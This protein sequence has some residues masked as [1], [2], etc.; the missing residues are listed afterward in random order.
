[1]K[2]R[3]NHVLMGWG[4]ALL[5]AS[6]LFSCSARPPG[7]A[8]TR[9]EGGDAGREAQAE[10][11]V[12]TVAATVNVEA[13]VQ[14]AF[15]NAACSCEAYLVA[16]TPSGPTDLKPQW[17]LNVS[18][19]VCTG[20]PRLASY[21]TTFNDLQKR[22][23]GQCV[24]MSGGAPTTPSPPPATTRQIAVDE[25][26][27]NG[28]MGPVPQDR[29]GQTPS[30]GF[31]RADFNYCVGQQLRL[32]A[33]SLARPPSSADARAKILEEARH[34]F[35]MAGAEF[36]STL[37][38]VDARKGVA[39]SAP[40]VCFEL[41][42][43]EAGVEVKT[44][45]F[46]TSCYQ[47]C[48]ICGGPPN[49]QEPIIGRPGDSE[50][51]ASGGTSNEG[52]SA[53]AA[54]AE[55]GASAE[56]GALAEPAALG[57][58]GALAEPAALGEAGALAE[59]G[60]RA[61]LG[62]SGVSGV[63]GVSGR[64]GEA[65]AP[66][67]GSSALC[68]MC[69]HDV[70]THTPGQVEA[71]TWC[72]SETKMFRDGLLSATPDEFDSFIEASGV[73]TSSGSNYVCTISYKKPKFRADTA[74]RESQR[75]ADGYGEVAAN[76]LADAMSQAADLADAEAQQ[77]AASSDGLSIAGA[78]FSSAMWGAAGQRTL[79]ARSLFGDRSPRA[80]ALAPLPRRVQR[81]DGARRALELLEGY[82][83]PMP[84][85]LCPAPGG[86]ES[87]DE[88]QS[89]VWAA[90]AYAK[91][92]ERLAQQF[93]RPVT[94]GPA[95]L[96]SEHALELPHVR[97]A[98]D[99]A[100]DR[101]EQLDVDYAFEPAD[102]AAPGSCG[103]GVLRFRS[104]EVR[105]REPNAL[106]ASFADGALVA[107]A[108]SLDGARPS[109]QALR[110]VGAAGA[111]DLVRAKTQALARRSTIR[112][113]SASEGV[114]AALLEAS[115]FVGKTWSDWRPCAQEPCP[116]P[117]DTTHWTIWGDVGGLPSTVIVL[118]SEAELSCWRRGHLP[119]QAPGAACPTGIERSLSTV[120]QG[121]V[122]G[123]TFSMSN[124]GFGP[125][126]RAFVVGRSC[127]DGSTGSACRYDLLDVIY[128]KDARGRHAF[129]GKLRD[130]LA[131]LFAKDAGNPAEAAFN[132]LG[133]E[134]GFVPARASL[135][136]DQI[137]SDAQRL[138]KSL[139]D[140]RQGADL[141][142]VRLDEATALEIEYLNH[143]RS[144]VEAVDAARL[145][146]EAVIGGVCVDVNAPCAI[147]RAQPY[148]LG[149]LG[150]VPIA[151]VD[152][153]GNDDHPTC[154]Q[155]LERA[156]FALPGDGLQDYVE[157]F[158]GAALRCTRW[159]VFDGAAK[160]R[161]PDLP[162]RVVDEILSGGDGGFNNVNRGD[163][164]LGHELKPLYVQLFAQLN[165]LR[166]ALR[167]FDS[168]YQIAST[169]LRAAAELL[170]DADPSLFEEITCYAGNVVQA[171]QSVVALAAVL[172][173][174]PTPLSVVGGASATMALIESVDN[175]SE[176]NDTSNGAQAAA[177]EAWAGALE[178]MEKMRSFGDSSARLIGSAASFDAEF[179]ALEAGLAIAQK[180]RALEE[181]V[182]QGGI[183]GDPAWRAMQG[184][185]Q[186]EARRLLRKA[187]GQAFKARRAVEFRTASDLRWLSSPASFD[188]RL[189]S[190]WASDLFAVS[191]A[192][193]G[194]GGAVVPAGARI[195]EY[196]NRLDAFVDDYPDAYSFTPANDHA[197]LHFR[198]IVGTQ[199]ALTDFLLFKCA[200]HA[201]LLPG[202]A[203]PSQPPPARP[204]AN[205]GRGVVESA[206]LTFAVP[207]TLSG[208]YRGRF[209]T[210]NTNYRVRELAV[211]LMADGL[212]NCNLSP[213]P[214]EC[215]LD[216]TLRYDLRQGD[217]VTLGNLQGERRSYDLGPA[218]IRQARALANGTTL[219]LPLAPDD[220]EINGPDFRRLGFE[221]RPLA[222]MYTLTL[223]S[224][225]EI[226]W[227]NL[228]DVQLLI[229]YDYWDP[230]NLK[231][232]APVTRMPSLRRSGGAR[233]ARPVFSLSRS[234]WGA[235]GA[236]L[237]A[238]LSPAA[239]GA[240][241]ARLVA[242]LLIAAAAPAP[243]GAQSAGGP[244][245]ALIL[246][247]GQ[248]SVRGMGE[249]FSASLGAG[250]A[251]YSVPIA[252]PPGRAGVGPSFALQ[253]GSSA[254]SSAL[255]FGWSLPVPFVSRQLERGVPRYDDR[256]RWHPE[257]DRF[258][259][260]GGGELVPVSDADALAFD[261][262]PPPPEAAGW[263]QYRPQVQGEPARV[264]RAPDASRWLVQSPTGWRYEF[265]A[266]APGEGPAEAEAANARQAGPGGQVSRWLLA[267]AC[268]PHGSCVYYDYDADQGD[269]YLAD[270]Y[271]V[272]PASCAGP[273]PAE[274]RGCSAPF[275]EYAVRVR[276][277]YEPRPDAFTSYAAGFA[278]RSSKRLQRVEVT[279]AG[280]TVGARALVRR[281]RLRYHATSFHSLLTEVQIEGRPEHLDASAG[282]NV[283]EA[284]V[285]ESSLGDAVVGPLL[286]PL[287]FRYTGDDALTPAGLP[288]LDATVRA[289]PSSPNVGLNAGTAALYDVNADGLVDVVDTDVTRYQTAEGAPA[290][291]VFFNG[292]TGAQA[293]VGARGGFSAAVPVPVPAGTP[294]DRVSLATATTVLSD[295]TGDGIAELLS[296]PKQ[297]SYGY[298]V[299]GHDPARASVSPADQGIELA[300]V[301]VT[302]PPGTLDPR[303][304][305]AADRASI[306][307]FDANNDGLVDLVRTGGSV[308]QTWL[309]LGNLPGGDGRY[310]SA[311]FE[312]GAWQLSTAPLEACLP[313]AP[314]AVLS[315]AD[316]A[317][318]IADMNGD[319]VDD[320]VR[321]GSN[322]VVYFPGR[323]GGVWG[324]GAGPCPPG[325]IDGLYVTLAASPT[326]LGPGN[327]HLADVDMDGAA[328]LLQVADGKISAW[329]N[330]GGE[331]FAER[332]LLRNVPFV[333]DAS[334][335]RVADVDGSGTA[336]VVFGEGNQYKW[337]DPLG[338]KRP[339][340]L[341]E[342]DGGLGSLA[343]IVYGSSAEDY[344]RDL[345]H[346]AAGA[347]GD[348]FLW[349]SPAA[350]CDALA[351]ERTGRC[352]YPLGA[353]PFV[354]TV[355][356]SFSVSDRL[357]ALGR[358]ANVGRTEYAYHDAYYEGFERESRG[359]GA[360]DARSIG[361]AS[362][363][364][365]TAR[366]R[367][368]LAPRPSELGLDRL[369]PN[370]DRALAG[371]DYQIE[372]F[373][374][375][376]RT[377]ST[378]HH[379]F[380]VRKLF[381]GLDGRRV[382]AAFVSRTDALAYDLAAEAGP[383]PDAPPLD[384]G[385]TPGVRREQL[386]PSQ[387]PIPDTSWPPIVHAVKV[388]HPRY[389][390]TASTVDEIDRF[391]QTLR[392]TAHGRLRGEAGEPL[393]DERIVRR[394]EPTLVGGSAWL[395]RN[396]RTWTEGHGAAGRLGETEEHFDAQTGDALAS[397][398]HV[399]LPRLFA[400]GGD[401]QGAAAHAQRAE[402]Q[403]SSSRV[404]AW[405]N[406]L[407]LCG[408]G[409]LAQGDAG[410]LRHQTR[411]YD[412]AYNQVVVAES[413]STGRENGAFR[414]LTSTAEW[415][416]G[417]GA[418]TRVVGPNGEPTEG[419]YD[420]FGRVAFVR[421]PPVAGC[422]GTRV[423]TT[424]LRYVLSAEPA[425]S[426]L[427]YVE[428]I[429]DLSC[430]AP[431]ADV[432]IARTYVDGLGRTRAT[433]VR[434]EAPHAWQ[435]SGVAVLDAGGVPRLA[436]QPDFIDE[437]SP[438]PARA[439]ALPSTPASQ[440]T[441]DAFG[442]ALCAVEPDGAATCT[443][444][445]A[446]SEDVCDAL[447]RDPASP[448]FETCTTTRRDGHGRV[449]DT[450]LRNRD[451][452]TGQDQLLRSFV[453]YRAD[454]VTVAV[455]RAET[456]NDAPVGLAQPVAGRQATR[457]FTLDS[458][459]RRLAA[460][461]Q[462]ADARR[463]GATEADRTWRYLYNRVGDLVAV[464]DPRGCGKNAFYDLAGRLLGEQYVG[465]ADAQ[466]HEG[467]AETLP[468][469]AIALEA[470]AS[471]VDVDVRTYFD[472]YPPWATGDLAPPANA[473]GVLGE[474]TAESDRASRSVSA[475][476]AR[477]GVVFRARQI[478]APPVGAAPAATL[479]ASPTTPAPQDG[480]APAAP[481]S[482]DEAHTY[483]STFTFDHGGRPRGLTLPADPDFGPSP[484][485]IGASVSY[486]ARGL[487]EKASLVV[488]GSVVPVIASVT[489]ARDG[490]PERVTYGDA[491]PGRAATA[492]DYAYDA[493][494]RPAHLRTL[495]SP[496][497]AAS[498]S[499]PL[500][501]V[502]AVNDQSFA[503]DAVSNLTAINDLR[504]PTQWPDGHRPQSIAIQ[505][506][507][508]YRVRQAS[509]AYTRDDGASAPSDAPSDWRDAA[510]ALRGADPMRPG[511][512]PRVAAPPAGRVAGLRWQHDW[513]GN[514]TRADDD[515]RVFYERSLG[516][517]T[518]GN[519]E[520]GGRPSALRL[521]ADLPTAAPASASPAAERG[522][523]VEVDYGE[524]GFV[525]ALTVKGQCTDVSTEQACWDDPAQ[526]VDARRAL[527]R[528]RCACQAEQRYEY[529]WD[530]LGQIADARRYDRAGAGYALA[531]RLRYRYDADGQRLIKEVSADEAGRRF[532]LEIVPG[533]FERRGLRLTPE[534]IYAA[535]P[536]LGTETQYLAA[537]A[538]V[539]W[540]DGEP[541][542]PPLL[543]P[544]HRIT[545]ALGDLLGTTSAVID[546][547]SGELIESGAYLPTGVRETWRTSDEADVPLEPRGFTGKEAD[548]E[549][550]LT[551]F[552]KRYLLPHLGRWASPDPLQ[553]HAG[554]GG[555]LLNNYHYVSGNLL[556]A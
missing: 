482:F 381:A 421:L 29:T 498:P 100:R 110:N 92:G 164:K 41:D 412:E 176:C 283:G 287:R 494:R 457:V 325:Q 361:D 370:P 184:Y 169:K 224:R 435:R 274:T 85:E 441:H 428:S 194:S 102:G 500:S 302:L 206:Q 124:A 378:T 193:L 433:L 63:S 238:A 144:S 377:V 523:Y 150:L 255:G 239:A 460:T 398:V 468:A 235:P 305:L 526:G 14:E 309:N 477:G 139:A 132:S 126:D 311:R 456:S 367:F 180:R 271:Y 147:G 96:L 481:V 98:L 405:G 116:G 205:V 425:A 161:L 136:D 143:L 291:G 307:A 212:Y 252:L 219:E 234:S 393:P 310:G 449:V 62:E 351:L 376:G 397:I 30:A 511:A 423:P 475:F 326:G 490:K 515:A 320:L 245:S 486:N 464:R 517:I 114:Q 461:D 52:A 19:D 119:G 243:V 259:Y 528:A 298:F 341:R 222:G 479:P 40:Q 400:F 436:Y 95:L 2:H 165:E 220:D 197:L 304:D 262:A 81:D 442:R 196:V 518:N 97:A 312:G 163:D 192:Y 550:G 538:R 465:C 337:V 407:E 185:R 285:A 501:A 157:D 159:A 198:S 507:A 495:R 293:G 24:H 117:L 537:G 368:H 268:D 33:D 202:G 406:P 277:V 208:Y 447:D 27:R 18:A 88:A 226:L 186:Q 345:A 16:P 107:Q 529:R 26:L 429:V 331:R 437:A 54:L 422:E 111:I 489:Y 487:E 339:R 278:V 313:R 499:R 344:L 172:S 270:A 374:D 306:R 135:R 308:L 125:D 508:L 540:K 453:A 231:R 288:T 472:A 131:R 323:G 214:Q 541:P 166:T 478:A 469:G 358:E 50:V 177:L 267:R 221:G 104:R 401:A 59:L 532:A 328:D 363:P 396:G 552:G 115:D 431:G 158:L 555:E 269:R 171:A 502:S 402:D 444:H 31:C 204:C 56:L 3:A 386:A 156:S 385:G 413:M 281:Y 512:A 403:V 360:A 215:N 362:R 112:D 203:L 301:P 292:F 36:A 491:G 416:R 218:L 371:R 516:R 11:S 151:G 249:S 75:V 80:G 236:R 521:A 127:A 99:L 420:G 417:L 357:S 299:V 452:E 195:T 462:D 458:T 64:G 513:L 273:S 248:G 547:T 60:A 133:I 408:G 467:P 300:Y 275:G 189:P 506:D 440:A 217:V 347:P 330:R 380:T 42:K 82:R 284:S 470:T 394:A 286:P 153:G 382:D 155:F 389:A 366:S 348:R 128:P 359:F 94:D 554:G 551:Y 72:A 342:V 483:V 199:G 130:G 210:G 141:A 519:E 187:Q 474:A 237:M 46:T 329:L 148:T 154:R 43:V 244:G 503:W 545:V 61:A 415:D 142:A 546:L 327:L 365:H 454:G 353:S 338:G 22:K 38:Q 438:T 55:S 383:S 65:R 533:D 4:T 459:G 514:V 352:V 123:R 439:L 241:R 314:G 451:P 484:P 230:Q 213:Y 419:G 228:E 17:A 225:P 510:H 103:R 290:V 404:D 261:G 318:R 434:A 106:A 253:Y 282:S 45:P 542:P 242:S 445:H 179:D 411:S 264:Y 113:W 251:G 78:N 118:R 520:P 170:E 167:Q 23:D 175:L 77:R 536:A 372:A 334:R 553:I 505:H 182:A 74:T 149:Q 246:P 53:E 414:S 91:L 509:Y 448:F 340:L 160:V 254:G 480:G 343:T 6:Q 69:C 129:G 466:P 260:S 316:A 109:T 543:D 108:C 87:L 39:C 455:T 549:V 384:A 140:A 473:A 263:Q 250:S 201:E 49:C 450:V 426:P 418:I 443:T 324:V 321:L 548:A 409:D 319:G 57:E 256:P 67:G 137:L 227:E 44:K 58:A 152:P 471:A 122:S 233:G 51:S 387:A 68:K 346:A 34:R 410:C 295:V 446:L 522:G 355:V 317:V 354:S 25:R 79:A 83:V 190:Q 535:D 101:V 12:E 388:R 32:K 1:M 493:R 350:G 257:E 73:L 71:S 395:W 322:A 375:A 168:T 188:G 66:G 37:E 265:G 48:T 121:G 21:V 173:T 223:T 369:A 178:S 399:T 146:Q 430:V 390:H 424:R 485:S 35:E 531:A 258:V 391:G 8:S 427:N 7:A 297:S 174:P 105:Q 497:G 336:D 280:A 296:M 335:V 303:I 530:E 70:C 200:G 276:F 524:G 216:Q 379:A 5:A 294:T 496:T 240:R 504:P 266:V 333:S 28:C 145:A 432:A 356:R 13:D 10:Q 183:Q 289:A 232:G 76:R 476:D 544:S 556:Q 209:A 138:V 279:S 120:T 93:G 181:R 211:N 373:D 207:S 15:D 463:P 349:R 9:G 539:V 191:A 20:D 89:G 392:A 364:S 162:Q 492:T 525:S 247:S 272:S 534:G 134:N 315:F 229:H 90:G 84:Y 47:E 527:L 488:D 86:W 332:I